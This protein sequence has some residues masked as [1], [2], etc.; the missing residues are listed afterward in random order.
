MTKA[1]DFETDGD[2]VI[3][4]APLPLVALDEEDLWKL[5]EE[6]SEEELQLT[7]RP[8]SP[9]PCAAAWVEIAFHSLEVA[10]AFTAAAYSQHRLGK[11]F[12]AI[13]RMVAKNYTRRKG[14][15]REHEAEVTRFDISV[16]CDMKVANGYT[17]N[18]DRESVTT[19]IQQAV[20]EL[21][22]GQDPRPG[23]PKLKM[24]FFT[25][26]TSSSPEAAVAKSK[27]T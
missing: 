9:F 11:I 27:R 18:R 14:T 12:E 13:D 25:E 15:P 10:V 3:I 22:T 19:A 26:L 24:Q 17:A 5:S 23:A 7:L 6:L 8:A 1:F 4:S 2:D 21:E 20:I 16:R